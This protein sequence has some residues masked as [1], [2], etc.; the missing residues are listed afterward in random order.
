MSQSAA[1]AVAVSHPPATRLQGAW[2]ALARSVWG[3]VALIDLAVLIPGLPAFAAQLQT[4]CS[5][6]TG[7]SCG[8]L[9][10]APAQLAALQQSG[11]SLAGYASYGVTLDV[12]STALLI[13][14]GALLFWHKSREPMGLFVSLF[15][16][17]YG[18]FGLDGSHL[19]GPGMNS[20]LAVVALLF[21]FLQWPAQGILFFTFP[22]GHFVPRWS[23]LLAFLFVLQFGFY[24]LPYPYNFDHWPLLL[25]TLETVIVYGSMVGTQVYRYRA[26]AS[27]IQRQQIKWLAFGFTLALLLVACFSLLPLLVPALNDAAS[28]YQLAGPITLVLG[29]LPIALGIGI[30]LLRYRLWDIDTLINKALVYGGLST[31]L[32]VLYVGLILG[33]ESLAGAIT[34]T[35]NQ[36]IAL[37][38]STL[39]I[40]ALFRPVRSRLQR[41]IDRR[42]YRKKYDAAKTLAALSATLRNE[43]DLQH[44]CAHLVAVVQ[45]TMQPAHIS[46]WLR[47]PERPPEDPAHHLEPQGQPSPESSRD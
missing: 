4:V 5:D 29:Y 32:G 30:A 40:A 39:L 42:F 12:A 33:L 37:V 11:L 20:P 45:E 2:L 21:F 41:V 46:L 44:I 15:L 24:V 23:W 16:I 3:L 10:L 7:V 27:P 17:T 31:L 25:S 14:L 34:D 19:T 1:S 13:L 8:V 28:P 22:D 35:A 9:Q 6:P 47:Q 38:I 26:V 43:V 18:S 36:P